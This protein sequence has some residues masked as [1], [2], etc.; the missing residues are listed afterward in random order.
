VSVNSHACSLG[1]ER[2]SWASGLAQRSTSIVC[3]GEERGSEGWG[4]RSTRSSDTRRS[5]ACETSRD[6][7]GRWWY[8]SVRWLRCE[9]DTA[10][11]SVQE[12]CRRGHLLG[13]PLSCF[14]SCNRT[15]A[16]LRAISDVARTRSEEGGHEV[17][18]ASSGKCVNASGS[19][20]GIGSGEEEGGAKREEGLFPRPCSHH[21]R[22]VLA[23]LLLGSPCCSPWP[24][25][26][27]R[28]R[29]RT[30]LRHCSRQCLEVLGPRG[31]REA[32]GRNDDK[33]RIARSGF[34]PR[35][36]AIFVAAGAHHTCAVLSDGAVRCWGQ[37]DQGQV[38]DGTTTNRLTAIPV[39]IG[40]VAVAISSGA[41]HTCAVLSDGSVQCW[42]ELPLQAPSVGGAT[43]VAKSATV[44]RRR[45]EHQRRYRI[46]AALRFP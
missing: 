33:S 34:E 36:A 1:L 10:K 32:W 39:S 29:V 18:D 24:R 38:G 6:G 12:R 11:R 40:G 7:G 31:E 4:A 44:R 19:E 45:E 3:S 13:H 42:G 43:A 22:R 16:E 37:N 35:G 27:H 17:P 9:V 25:V 23:V 8:Q 41:Y 2:A 28:Y 21:D 15:C 14:H 46:S 26:S 20:M 30:Y 5:A